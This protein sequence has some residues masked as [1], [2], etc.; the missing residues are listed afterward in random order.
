MEPLITDYFRCLC[1]SERIYEY[2]MIGFTSKLILKYSNTQILKYSNTQILK[3]SNT[4]I[5]KYSTYI[6]KYLAYCQASIHQIS[7]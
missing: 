3:Y 7:N 1:L 4:Q 2:Q 5:L 6:N